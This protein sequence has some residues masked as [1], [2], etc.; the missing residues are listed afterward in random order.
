[1]KRSLVRLSWRKWVLFQ[2]VYSVAA[3]QFGESEQPGLHG[4]HHAA[5]ALTV[6]QTLWSGTVGLIQT[7]RVASGL[8]RQTIEPSLMHSGP[9][10]IRGLSAK[11]CLQRLGLVHNGSQTPTCRHEGKSCSDWKRPR[12]TR[13]H[14][15]P[16][17]TAPATSGW[18]PK[19]ASN[20]EGLW[21][22]V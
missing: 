8:T 20:C 5:A 4:V 10:G 3:L 2:D 16:K 11:S 9:F 22:L 14:L 19:V 13:L 18:V 1:M 21:H 7:R 17:P 15:R 6:Q 12:F